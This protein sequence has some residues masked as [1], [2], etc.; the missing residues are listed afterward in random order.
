MSTGSPSLACSAN[1]LRRADLDT[2][3]RAAAAAGFTG[4]GLRVSDYRDAGREDAAIRDLL[5]EHELRVLELEH[6]WDWSG[7]GD[8]VEDVVF[9]FADRIGVR[10][11]NVPMFVD[12]PVATL[13][14]GFAGLCDRAAAHGLLIGLEFLPYAHVRTLPA[15]AEIVGSA[16]R[17]NGGLVIDLWHWFR[18]GATPADLQ[19]VPADTIHSVQLCDVAPRAEADLMNEARHRRLLPGQGAGDTTAVLDALAAHGVRSP[20]SVEVFSDVLDSSPAETAAR[21]AFRAGAAVLE[22]SSFTPTDR[23]PADEERTG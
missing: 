18:S 2:R 12:H 20:A 7:A 11:L 6:T 21:L 17:P 22:R 3:V 10:Q 9:R 15:A 1:T 14:R 4:I 5:A 16:D 13:V 8:P 23:S 19:H